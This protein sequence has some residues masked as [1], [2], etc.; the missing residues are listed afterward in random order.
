MLLQEL[1]PQ[2]VKR[3]LAAALQGLYSHRAGIT[4][5]TRFYGTGLLTLSRHPIEDATCAAFSRQTFEEG[6]FGPRRMLA[7]TVQA[8][9]LGPV[10][11]INLHATAG[12]AYRKR[13]RGTPDL[14]SAQLGEATTAAVAP[15]DG[16]AV[17]GG[18][19]NCTPASAPWVAERLQEAGLRR[20]RYRP[21]ARHLGPREPPQLQPGP[22]RGR[23]KAG[24]LHLRTRGR[25][26]AARRS[27]SPTTT[28]SSPPSPPPDRGCL[29][30][31]W[32]AA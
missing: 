6:L 20:H 3:A 19:F 8:P 11:A 12:S 28:A 13:R 30:R 15:F 31:R 27:P 7:C 5:D 10:R 26:A 2:R 32:R 16:T 29:R 4:E 18:D 25:R 23:R 17:L 21:L 22:R 24:R 14:R 1:V 9:G